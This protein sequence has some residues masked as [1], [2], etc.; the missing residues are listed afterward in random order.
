LNKIYDVGNVVIGTNIEI[1]DV[2]ENRATYIV[3]DVSTNF[4]T[5]DKEIPGNDCFVYGTEVDDFHALNKDYIFT[6]N[7]C[8]TQELNKKIDQ[9]NQ[10]INDL[11]NR[12]TQLE[13]IINNLST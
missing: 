1:I 8:A 10:T 6:L 11:I 12:I 4:I 2:S 5:I 13:N 3:T 7:V 9:Q